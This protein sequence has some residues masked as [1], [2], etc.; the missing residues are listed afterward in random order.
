MNY[1]SD[2]HSSKVILPQNSTCPSL[3]HMIVY[4]PA[5]SLNHKPLWQR[6]WYFA[7]AGYS[8]LTVTSAPQ[9]NETAL[10][11][12][13][14][15][16]EGLRWIKAAIQG[17]PNFQ[18]ASA[19]TRWV[20]KCI[21]PIQT[22]Q[23]LVNPKTL[24]VNKHRQGYWSTNTEILLQNFPQLLQPFL[25]SLSPD[26]AQHSCLCTIQWN[27]FLLMLCFMIQGHISQA[28]SEWPQLKAPSELRNIVSVLPLRHTHLILSSIHAHASS[29]PLSSSHLEF[30]RRE[31]GAHSHWVLWVLWVLWCSAKV[32]C[33]WVGD[34][35]CL[36]QGLPSIDRSGC[37]T[38]GYTSSLKTGSQCKG[39][40][41]K[42]P[43]ASGY[44]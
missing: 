42:G 18:H 31:K 43:L 23:V 29:V 33:L 19:L 25:G 7:M 39:T 11:L 28:F 16:W 21:F 13:S 26:V 15:E 24:V 5:L 35:V 8:S 14:K 36:Y 41:D 10:G 30:C 22:Q 27:T 44:L 2:L 38:Q 1:Y 6:I 20:I 34:I 4:I 17:F 40:K 37:L 32:S 9:V 3:S 12:S